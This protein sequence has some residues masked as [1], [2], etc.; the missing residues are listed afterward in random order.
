MRCSGAVTGLDVGGSERRLEQNASTEREGD[1]EDQHQERAPPTSGTK[2]P[3]HRA[4]SR[5]ASVV[6]RSRRPAPRCGYRPEGERSCVDCSPGRRIVTVRA[7]VK[8]AM[9]DGLASDERSSPCYGPSRRRSFC[10]FCVLLGRPAPGSSAQSGTSTR[11]ERGRMSGG[12]TA[13]GLR[14]TSPNDSNTKHKR[15]EAWLQAL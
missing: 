7:V 10:F 9:K 4:P 15:K 11:A 5:R 1:Q 3:A 13:G 2:D 14:E 6:S 12:A 8:P